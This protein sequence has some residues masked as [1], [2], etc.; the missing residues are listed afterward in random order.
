MAALVIWLGALVALSL[1][2]SAQ[3]RADLWHS[4]FFVVA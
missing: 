2:E 4:Y 1:F 3:I